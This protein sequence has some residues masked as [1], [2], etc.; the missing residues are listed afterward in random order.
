[1]MAKATRMARGAGM[2]EGTRLSGARVEDWPE[3]L[4]RKTWKRDQDVERA[5]QRQE[6]HKGLAGRPEE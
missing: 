3:R 4:E 6:G 5:R 2:A 1:M